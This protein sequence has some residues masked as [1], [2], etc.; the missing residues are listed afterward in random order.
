MVRNKRIRNRLLEVPLDSHFPKCITFSI[1]IASL[2]KTPRPRHGILESLHCIELS[3]GHTN[4][5]AMYSSEI[6]RLLCISL[7]S[8]LTIQTQG[9]DD[10]TLTSCPNDSDFHDAKRKQILLRSGVLQPSLRTERKRL[11][12]HGWIQ[13]QR[14][15]G[16]HAR[17]PTRDNSLLVHQIFF[18]RDTGWRCFTSFASLNL[19]LITAPRYGNVSSLAIWT[20]LSGLGS[21]VLSSWRILSPMLRCFMR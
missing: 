2:H 10:Q 15:C 13:V 5:M 1:S 9:R 16:L 4:A 18:R 14:V 21:K 19:S 11:G 8:S 12:I 3:A 17:H 20:R 7:N 6:A